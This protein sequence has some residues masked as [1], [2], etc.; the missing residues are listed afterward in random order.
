MPFT[1][2]QLPRKV[3]VVMTWVDGENP[4]YQKK[5][6][7][8][9]AHPED[10]NPERFRDPYRLLRYGLRS[11]CA[12]MSDLSGWFLS[13][14]SPEHADCPPCSVDPRDAP[15]SFRNRPLADPLP[16]RDYRHRKESG[17]GRS[18][19]SRRSDEATAP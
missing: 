15:A 19:R 10:L 8:Y 14:Y 2:E 1:A 7:K 4:A 3:D 16:R 9:H 6:R 12:Q 17:A 5:L 13:F 18:N 11:V